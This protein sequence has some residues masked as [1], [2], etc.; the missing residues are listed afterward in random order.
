MHRIAA[1]LLLI[2]LLTPGSGAAQA[3]GSERAASEG[4]FL[5]PGDVIDVDIWREED[6]SGEFRVGMTGVVTLPLLGE[7]KVVGVPIQELRDALI[8]DYQ[9]HLRNPSINITPLRR[10]NILGSV[11][12][13][14]LYSVDPTISLAGAI[15]LAGGGTEAGDLSRIKILRDSRVLQ[16]RVGPAE[17]LIGIDL[18]SGDEIFVER[19]SWFDRNS[20]YLGSAVLST[21]LSIVATLII[22][23]ANK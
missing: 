17:T 20:G 22:T 18:R 15:A 21:V 7:R 14:G 1:L 16:E 10:V 8:R 23:N 4:P 2:I 12:K 11:A 6:L 5:L 9:V 19:R 13:P 3:V